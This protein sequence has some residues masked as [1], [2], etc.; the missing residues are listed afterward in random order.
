MRFTHIYPLHNIA[1][2]LSWFCIAS[3]TVPQT[4]SCLMLRIIRGEMKDVATS[5]V[6]TD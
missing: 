5:G 3:V 6:K 1:M 2:V 4:V